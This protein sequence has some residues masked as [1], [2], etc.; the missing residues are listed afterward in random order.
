MK[1]V[2][3]SYIFLS[4]LTFLIT[5]F[6][7]RS[8]AAETDYL[9]SL[10]IGFSTFYVYNF[11]SYIFG[12]SHFNDKKEKYRF[13]L[14]SLFVGLL[15]LVNLAELQISSIV[16]LSFAGL[17]CLGYFANGFKFRLRSNYLSKPLTIGVVF[18]ICTAAIPYLE[19]GY[20]LSESI[21]LSLGRTLFVST[22]AL[23]FDMGD[24]LQDRLERTT[25]FPAKWGLIKAKFFATFLLMASASI[26]IWGAWNF[27]IDLSGIV[28]LGFT[29][30]MTF[31]TIVYAK[32]ER[33]WWYYELFVDGLL[34]MPLL[35]LLLI[36]K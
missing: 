29:Y 28:A 10:W 2:F 15:F 11:H 14:N 9:Y 7:F 30:L 23:I 4:F 32:P 18:G 24:I 3:E 26:E 36:Q 17:F 20:L 16:L 22:L 1:K 8:I 34:A 31:V 6:T 12:G 35:I 5:V 33:K 27:L 21:F 19:S 25:T 13:S